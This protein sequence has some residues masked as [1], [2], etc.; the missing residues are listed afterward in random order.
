MEKLIKSEFCRKKNCPAVYRDKD[1][2]LFVQG[3]V[4]T[5]PQ[6][7]V[8]GLPDNETLIEVDRSLLEQ[9]ANGKMSL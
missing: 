7:L 8:P 3:F 4:V 5:N 2:R 6:S 1:G 9:I